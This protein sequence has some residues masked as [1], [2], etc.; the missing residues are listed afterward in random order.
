M[1]TNWVFFLVLLTDHILTWFFRISSTGAQLPA[2]ILGDVLGG[3]VAGD[4]ENR[5]VVAVLQLLHDEAEVRGE[6]RSSSEAPEQR[7]NVHNHSQQQK[8]VRKVL[9]CNTKCVRKS[10]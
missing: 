7:G 8:N 9:E 1:V 4:E 6:L 5:V 3:G 2:E 10:Q